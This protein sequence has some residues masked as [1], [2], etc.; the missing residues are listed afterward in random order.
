MR[1][2][3]HHTQCE[4]IEIPR[5]EAIIQRQIVDYLRAQNYLVIRL[6]SLCTKIGSRYLRAYWVF[7]L[8]HPSK[9]APDILAYRGTDAPLLIEVKKAKGVRSDVQIAFA[10]YALTKGVIVLC[11]RSVNEIIEHLKTIE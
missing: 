6:N 2:I 7:G 10:D 3:P 11:V 4:L 1:K 9:G 8:T 5:P